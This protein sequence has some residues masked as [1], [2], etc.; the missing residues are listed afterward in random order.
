MPHTR[1]TTDLAKEGLFNILQHQLEF[2]GLRTLD[3]FGGTGSISYELAS[4]GAV[5]LTVVERDLGMAAYIERTASELKLSGLRVVKYD[6]LRFL[7]EATGPY[8]FVFAGPPYAF[9][10]I[11]SLPDLI[12]DRSLLGAGGWFV[13]EHSP[14]DQFESY[15]GF[16]Q[17]R[18]YGSTFFSIFVN[19][20]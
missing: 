10:D 7:H 14:R 13:L 2:R 9:P 19:P 4:R 12:A 15:R 20:R 8:D 5:D 18:N 6:A 17:S 1:P 11:G 3:L 16:A